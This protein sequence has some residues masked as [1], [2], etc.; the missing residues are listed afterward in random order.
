MNGVSEAAGLLNQIAKTNSE[1]VEKISKEL[2][3]EDV[4]QTRRMATTILANAF[5]FHE[6]LAGKFKGVNSIDE[7]RGKKKFNK[8]SILAE[9]QK[10]LLIN[11]WPIFD[12]ARRILEHVPVQ[13]SKALIERLA[14]TAD[15]LLENQLMRSHDLTGAVFQRMIVDRKFLAAY[16]TTPASAALFL[17][18]SFPRRAQPVPCSGR[19]TAVPSLGQR[20]RQRSGQQVDRPL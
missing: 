13:E 14:E 10:I 17:S 3:Q 7:L 18:P 5:V 19:P 12:I 2:F 8:A 4:E 16:Y 9:W 11:Y 20:A 6:S 1:A 15:R